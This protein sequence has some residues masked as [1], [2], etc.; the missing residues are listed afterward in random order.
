[1]KRSLAPEEEACW[2]PGAPALVSVVAAVAAVVA[3]VVV[4]SF[5]TA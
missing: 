5:E 1:M 4:A 2:E 3:V